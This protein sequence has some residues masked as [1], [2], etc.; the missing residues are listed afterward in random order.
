MHYKGVYVGTVLRTHDDV[1][2]HADMTLPKDVAA[3]AP[4]VESEPKPE[5]VEVEVVETETE[6]KADEPSAEGS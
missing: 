2:A 1:A 6:A 4:P 3:P 5:V